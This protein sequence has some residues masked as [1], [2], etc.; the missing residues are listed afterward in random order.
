MLRKGRGGTILH[1]LGWCQQQMRLLE[2]GRHP[3][4]PV[5]MPT[6]IQGSSPAQLSS[7]KSLHTGTNLAQATHNTKHNHKPRPGTI[8]IQSTAGKS[9]LK[10]LREIMNYQKLR[11]RGLVLIN[12]GVQA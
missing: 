6:A 3:I 1:S 5:S 9:D 2:G 10:I 12:K 11:I 7:H 8:K 4:P